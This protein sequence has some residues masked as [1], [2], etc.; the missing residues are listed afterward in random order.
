MIVLE[1]KNKQSMRHHALREPVYMYI[2][3]MQKAIIYEATISDLTPQ[4]RITLK[5]RLH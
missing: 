5:G 2:R 1:L 3:L 4:L